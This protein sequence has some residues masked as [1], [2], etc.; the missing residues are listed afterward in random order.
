MDIIP[1]II[2]LAASLYASL[3]LL[4]FFVRFVKFINNFLKDI[5]GTIAGFFKKKKV[6]NN[7]IDSS[8]KINSFTEEEIEDLRRKKTLKNRSVKK[9]FFPWK[10]Y[11]KYTIMIASLP[12]YS[13]IKGKREILFFKMI[14]KNAIEFYPKKFKNK[15][16]KGFYYVFDRANYIYENLISK[17]RDYTT[18]RDINKILN[19]TKNIVY[20]FKDGRHTNVMVNILLIAFGKS[21][22]K[23]K[24][25]VPIA[26]SNKIK[27]EKRYHKF[28]STLCENTECHNGM[29]L[30]S[31]REKESKF[32]G[33]AR[34]NNNDFIIGKN[35]EKILLNKDIILIDD[36]YTTGHTS[37]LWISKFS[38]YNPKSIK[39][40]F[41]AKQLSPLKNFEKKEI[42]RVMELF[43]IL[44]K[45]SKENK[46]KLY[47]V[48]SYNIEKDIV[49]IVE[50]ESVEDIYTH[51]EAVLPEH[52][53]S[54]YNTIEVPSIF[55]IKI[56]GS[57]GATN[58]FPPYPKIK[59]IYE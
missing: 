39:C 24:L 26:A 56:M 5:Y 41:L 53:I 49:N 18:R 59:K 23:G 17:T 54:H 15:K 11:Y 33:G 29:N 51:E 58:E 42:V 2:F 35:I 45:T 28:I 8:E 40:I 16:I 22:F 13:L 32:K 25:I 1:I 43:W 57:S 31:V 14:Y 7:S 10:F 44:N 48:E 9:V 47:L 50:S 21:F 19:T 30:I 3:Y 4:I 6:S 37:H 36:I 55:V 20:D 52:T 27:N 38:E 34:L 46:D 12:Y